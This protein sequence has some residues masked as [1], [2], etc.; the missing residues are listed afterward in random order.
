MTGS[1][2]VVVVASMMSSVGRSVAC[3]SP[4]MRRKKAKKPSFRLTRRKNST[5]NE[6][7]IKPRRSRFVY[8]VSISFPDFQ[9]A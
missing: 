9:G 3:L 1:I 8:I 7:K 4:R 6:I 2:V 5:Q